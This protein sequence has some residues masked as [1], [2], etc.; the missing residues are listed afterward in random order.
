MKPFGVTNQ[1]C[2]VLLLV[3][4]ILCATAC[5]VDTQTFQ[6]SLQVIMIHRTVQ[7]VAGIVPHCL[8]RTRV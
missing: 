3:T 5:I 4:T 1:K 8:V 6:E 2:G 7:N